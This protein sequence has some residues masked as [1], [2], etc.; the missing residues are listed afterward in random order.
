MFCLA[1]ASVSLLQFISLGL[2]VF[3][4][5]S[6]EPVQIKRKLRAGR[7]ED[8]E[9]AKVEERLLPKSERRIHVAGEQKRGQVVL[10]RVG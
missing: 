7:G 2:P 10:T 3:F 1:A 8:R 4:K 5:S 6:L 9:V